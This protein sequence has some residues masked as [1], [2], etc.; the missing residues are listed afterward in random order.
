MAL[1]TAKRQGEEKDAYRK[2][3][4]AT[5]EAAIQLKAAQRAERILSS[6]GE[7]VISHPRDWIQQEWTQIAVPANGFRPEDKE[8]DE[9]DPFRQ[10]V[11]DA[12]VQL[13]GGA[14]FFESPGPGMPKTSLEAR[15]SNAMVEAIA[16]DVRAKVEEVEAAQPIRFAW[17]DFMNGVMGPVMNLKGYKGDRTET[18]I[19]GETGDEKSN[20]LWRA[21][22]LFVQHGTG[23]LFEE[24]E[25]EEQSRGA[26][27]DSTENRLLDSTIVDGLLHFFSAP[28]VAGETIDKAFENK[29]LRAL[30]EE[31]IEI[32]VAHEVESTFDTDEAKTNYED[33]F[34]CMRH[35]A[36]E[37]GGV[38]TNLLKS[39]CL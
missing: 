39:T 26:E 8:L 1:N 37:E 19:D 22:K 3:S 38:L 5:R 31:G 15:L 12:V 16:T 7:L 30:I 32:T 18:G 4:D 27:E 24:I 33:F 13:L 9:T 25:R 35:L 28:F 21:I 17:E 10:A 2:F 20:P 29:F 11:S 36:T 34:K 23:A 14:R 6:K